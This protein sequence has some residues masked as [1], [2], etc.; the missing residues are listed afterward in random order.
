MTNG[1]NDKGEL[2]P[3]GYIWGAPYRW[4]TMVIAY[5]KNKFKKHKL[6]PIKDWEDLWRPELAGKISMIDSPRE[7]I[8]AVLKHM[9]ASY[10]TK[11]IESQ[12]TGG[13]EA[14]LYNLAMLQKQVRLFDSAHYLKSFAAGDV[15][16]AVGWSS[17]VLPAAKR[18]SNVAVIVP[19][20]G[21][22]LWTD[23]W[24]IPAASRFPSDQIGGRVRGPSPLIHQWIEFCL[25]T[26]RGLPFQEQVIPGASPFALEHVSVTGTREPKKGQPE[27]ETNLIDGVP[28]P[29]ILSKCELL[30]PL[31]DKAVEDHLWL[32]SSMQK[33]DR[34]WI[35]N[36]LKNVFLQF[37]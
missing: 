15:W 26:A 29:E 16:V 3:N 35:Q 23:L 7:V 25:Q 9:G 14:V 17:D 32:I 18:M 2:D 13:K 21:A 4:G 37:G 27:L 28:P 20:S 11:D 22:S 10:N 34:G 19:S 30:E 6:T 12:V 5:K 36:V 31:S 24:A 8:G 33:P 1:R